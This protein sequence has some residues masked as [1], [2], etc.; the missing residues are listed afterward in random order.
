MNNGEIGLSRSYCERALKT[1]PQC[2]P[3]HFI[4]AAIIYSEGDL[5]TALNIYE[6]ILLYEP[7]NIDAL[8]I[9]G[10]ILNQYINIAFY[11]NNARLESFEEEIL[12]HEALVKL[13]P[14]DPES[15]LGLGNAQQLTGQYP[16]ALQSFNRAL[17]LE[18]DNLDALEQKVFPISAAI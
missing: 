12:V 7:R 6:D 16:E 3:A 14:R 5:E 10:V 8:R 11:S 1:D 13:R 17:E 2:V 4:K 9:M 18:P 15:F